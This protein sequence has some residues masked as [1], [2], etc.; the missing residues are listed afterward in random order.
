ML[1]DR[2]ILR[3][4]LLPQACLRFL[5]IPAAWRLHEVPC[6]HGKKPEEED[7]KWQQFTCTIS[8]GF[9]SVG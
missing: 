3:I 6:R 1:Q 5:V 9:S 2:W 7:T 4:K 8:E